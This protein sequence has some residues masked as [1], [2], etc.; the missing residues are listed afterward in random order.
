F[1]L[2]VEVALQVV[3]PLGDGCAAFLGVQLRQ[4]VVL[5]VSGGQVHDAGG[6]G[7]GMVRVALVVAAQEGDVDGFGRRVRPV[8]GGGQGEQVAVDVVDGVIVVV[9]L[10]GAGDVVVD[11]DLTGVVRH[12]VRDGGHL[13]EVA[14]DRL[15]DG[16]V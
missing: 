15:R 2:G 10:Q 11:E 14:F 5:L 7:D 1:G 13:A 8:L 9:D 4:V 16:G 12:L 6:D 3:E